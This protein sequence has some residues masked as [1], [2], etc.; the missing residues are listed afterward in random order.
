MEND[1][2][3]QVLQGK[4]DNYL[5]PFFW[6][7]GEEQEV[8]EEYIEKMYACGCRAFCVESRTHPDFL[9]EGWWKDMDLILAK[10]KSLGM[11]VWILDDAHFPTGYANGRIATAP[12]ELKQWYLHHKEMDIPGPVRGGR[13]SITSK[14]HKSGMV[15]AGEEVISVVLVKRINEQDFDTDGTFMDLTD[16]V[17]DGWLYLELPEGYYRLYVTTRFRKEDRAFGNYIDLTNPESVKLLI[18]ETYEKHYAH[19]KEHFGNTI[20]GFFSDEPGFYNSEYPGGY[21][22]DC[23]IGADMMIP[24]NPYI[25]EAFGEKLRLEGILSTGFR[26]PLVEAEGSCNAAVIGGG[27]ENSEEERTSVRSLL[28]ALWFPCGEQ[29]EQIRACYMDAL[30]EL[31]HKHFTGQLADWCESHGVEYIGHVI[32]DDNNHCRLGCGPGH[33]FRAIS[34][35]HMSGIDVVLQAIMPG[36]DRIQYRTTS[37]WPHDGAFN[38]YGLAKLGSSLAHM[39]PKTRGRAMCEIFGAYGWEEGITLMKWLAD[40]MLVRGIN[41]FVP[42]AFTEKTF[43]DPDCPP[44]FYARGY[45]PQYRYVDKVFNYMNRVSHLLTGGRP[46]IRIGILYHGE[47]E[48]LGR[49][50]Y[51]HNIGRELYRKQI[52]YDVVDLDH[53]K[54]AEIAHGKIRIGMLELECLLIPFADR[55]P[56]SVKQLVERCKQADV[57][58]MQVIDELPDGG[59]TNHYWHFPWHQNGEILENCQQVRLEELTRPGAAELPGADKVQQKAETKDVLRSELVLEDTEG[60]ISWLRYYHYIMEDGHHAYMLFNESMDGCVSGMMKLPTVKGLVRYNGVDNCLNEVFYDVDKGMNLKLYPGESV[61]FVAETGGFAVGD[62]CADGGSADCSSGVC[63]AKEIAKQRGVHNVMEDSWNTFTGNIHISA[64]DYRNIEVF[65]EKVGIQAKELAEPKATEWKELQTDFSG[66]LRYELTINAPEG[67]H[68]LD[69]GSC[70]DAAQ[71]WI[72]GQNAGVKIG[73]PYHF[74]ISEG[75]RCGENHIR[76]EV[77]TTLVNM[78]C[79]FF[80]AQT[81]LQ[82]SGIQ[83]PVSYC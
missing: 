66:I 54:E 82:R 32:E 59:R 50:A 19:Y 15:P 40:H 4:E 69:L 38:F 27:E 8:V 24:W 64:A 47:M 17:K 53:L 14:P 72:N 33:F 51:F 26:A 5:L 18:E 75:S 37:G 16:Q 60:D 61:I 25:E 20:A 3:Q 44:H 46:V 57:R 9:N 70:K 81:V 49:A 35:Q 11:K 2:L 10:A 7:H 12:D 63:G 21:A 68:Y 13:V 22:F 67:L 65:E 62:D 71:V 6:L 48:W 23:Q 78:E 76:I 29:T 73:Y 56:D 52:D 28:P 80:S 31:Y 79:D 36:K 1:R 74:D 41:T 39:E 77:A 55:Y 30:T 34:G 45:N 83:G 43:P 58:V 42:H